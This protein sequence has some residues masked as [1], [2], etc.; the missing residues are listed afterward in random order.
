MPPDDRRV[1]QAGER[2]GAR[3]EVLGMNVGRLDVQVHAPC[4]E[5][6]DSRWNVEAKMA[7][8]GVLALFNK[9]RGTASSTF[10]AEGIRLVHSHTHVEDGD[11]WRDYEIWSKPGRFK[12]RFERASGALKAGKKRYPK[13]ETLYD[14]QT[15]VFAL[16]GWRPEPKERGYFYVV[17]GRKLWRADVQYLGVEPLET[18]RGVLS[19]V[20]FQGTAHRVDLDEGEEYTPRAF[21]VWMTNDDD[22][23]PVR[24]AGDGSIGSVTFFLEKHSFDAPCRA[25]KASKASPKTTAKVRKKVAPGGA[26]PTETEEGSPASEAA[27]VSVEPAV[28]VSPQSAA[29][30]PTRPAESVPPDRSPSDVRDDSAAADPS[31]GES[32]PEPAVDDPSERG[33]TPDGGDGSSVDPP[34]PSAPTK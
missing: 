4:D 17:L 33:A 29:G 2:F 32:L 10:E 23:I 12:Y 7:T 31:D 8:A 30:G 15:A 22:R 14:T 20:R 27:G 25:S 21:S 1:L 9:T 28:S 26:A 13:E 3:A 24:V 6:A 18:E 11:D 5:A 34:A 16:K 19:T